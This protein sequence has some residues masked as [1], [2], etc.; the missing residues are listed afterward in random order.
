MSES[1]AIDYV[2]LGRL[3]SGARTGRRLSLRKVAD[4]TKI[5]S[6][7]LSRI[8]RCEVTPDLDTVRALTTWI[9]VPLEKVV[10]MNVEKAAQSKTDRK[11]DERSLLHD[12]EVQFRA[13]PNLPPQAAEA[14]IKIMRTAYAALV[15][16]DEV[17]KRSK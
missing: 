7:T 14:L 6:S 11:E 1:D 17:E 10:R 16:T 9:G 5:S 12:V 8:E 4:E 15:L 2:G 13:A 3:L